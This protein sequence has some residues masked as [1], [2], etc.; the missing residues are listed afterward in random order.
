VA[1]PASRSS[2][3]RRSRSAVPWALLGLQLCLAC[4]TTDKSP[5]HD[6]QA[7][8]ASLAGTG[9]V[10]MGGTAAAGMATGGV[11]TNGGASLAGAGPSCPELPDPQA[12]CPPSRPQLADACSAGAVCDYDACG[13]GCFSPLFC[14][15]SGQPW[16]GNA[17]L[18][19]GTCETGSAE[20][21]PWTKTRTLMLAK[22]D[23]DCGMLG[24]LSYN[25]LAALLEEM[26]CEV[27]LDEF[28]GCVARRRIRCGEDAASLSIDMSVAFRSG[29]GWRG[30]AEVTLEGD[31][32]CSG[33]YSLGL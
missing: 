27:E 16:S 7:G 17:V 1:P 20:T 13:D 28:V 6:G 12:L 8:S 33:T 26:S 25:P 23:G 3:V 19:G 18:C 30:V 29:R 11:A 31:A 2:D 15:E 24:S 32:S 22:Q 10:G 14:G 4:G 5:P 21:S 9:A